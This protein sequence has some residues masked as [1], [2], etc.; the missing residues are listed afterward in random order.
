MEFE[1]RTALSEHFKMLEREGWIKSD[2]KI[3]Q[4]DEGTR[5]TKVFIINFEKVK[6]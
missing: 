6:A 4:I 3:E 5:V 2:Y 1:S